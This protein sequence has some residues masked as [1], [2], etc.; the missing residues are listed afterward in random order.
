MER[1]WHIYRA[2]TKQIFS[3]RMRRFKEWAVQNIKS[4][5]VL[6]KVIKFCGKSKMFQMFYDYPTA[7]RTSNMIDRLMDR[8]DRF[9]YIMKYFHGHF[10]SA[11]LGIRSWVILMN[12][13]PYCPRATNKKGDWV[14]AAQKLNGFRYHNN[15]LENFLI[16]SSMN[17]YRQ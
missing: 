2:S 1:I 5:V 12:F 7:Y 16:S 3:Q 14:C 10:I 11:E 15:W 8:Q 6:S 4:P 17:G 9:L 13:S